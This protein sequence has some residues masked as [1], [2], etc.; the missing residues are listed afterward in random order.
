MTALIVFKNNLLH[1]AYCRLAKGGE[2]TRYEK[3]HGYAALS[4][5]GSELSAR[6]KKYEVELESHLQKLL[7][8]LH[9]FNHFRSQ[10]IILPQVKGWIILD[11]VK[12]WETQENIVHV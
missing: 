2:R 10:W 11:Q 5:S 3:R 6:E 9:R 1:R 7:N 4:L 12:G 8:C